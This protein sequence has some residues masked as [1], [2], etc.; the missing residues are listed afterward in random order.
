MKKYR[1]RLAWY[2]A[3]LIMNF[4]FLLTGVKVLYLASLSALSYYLPAS[5]FWFFAGPWLFGE[6][7]RSGF[8][9]G[10]RAERLGF[11]M[12]GIGVLAAVLFLLQGNDR[13]AATAIFA[14]M[15]GVED[16]VWAR[17]SRS[18]LFRRR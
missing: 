5:I 6:R 1:Y 17:E 8:A 16:I 9:F 13:L 7:F 10:I 11:F 12:I 4:W 14:A 18:Y 3:V 2:F 15:C